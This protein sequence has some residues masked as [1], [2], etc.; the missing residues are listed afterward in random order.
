[1]CSMFRLCNVAID[2][3]RVRLSKWVP[4]CVSEKHVSEDHILNKNYYYY[5]SVYFVCTKTNN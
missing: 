3:D 2:L 5:T 1:M 4:A